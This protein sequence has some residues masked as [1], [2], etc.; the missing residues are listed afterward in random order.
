MAI[1]VA[2]VIIAATLAWRALTA[3]CGEEIE[4]RIGLLPSALIRLAAMRVRREVRGDL[5]REW[6]AE[7]DF[8]VS[9]T[10]GLPVTRLLRGLRF[11]ASLL[12][13]APS[14]AHELTCTCPPRRRLEIV[15]WRTW[16]L[17]FSVLAGLLL[18]SIRYALTTQHQ[19]T[20]G[21]AFGVI[22]LGCLI[23]SKPVWVSIRPRIEAPGG[24]R[25]ALGFSIMGAG[26]LIQGGGLGISGGVL[27][28][29]TG[30]VIAWA[31]WKVK[32]LSIEQSETLQAALFPRRGSA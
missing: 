22:A 32:R 28:V 18:G 20:L 23:V 12:R 2:I 1:L 25:F 8:I 4:T 6:A 10:K 7:L 26:F 16:K 21:I 14:V 19:A 13:F 5:T 11:A 24:T 15:A 29:V 31:C 17:L 9:G 27:N 30:A 3:M